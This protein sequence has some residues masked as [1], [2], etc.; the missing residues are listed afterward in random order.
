MRAHFLQNLALCHLVSRFNAVGAQ[1]RSVA[2]INFQVALLALRAAFNNR[3]SFLA[4]GISLSLSIRFSVRLCLTG[5]QVQMAGS[6]QPD[7]ALQKLQERRPAALWGKTAGD[8]PLRTCLGKRR[9][10]RR[11]YQI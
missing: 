9:F 8:F 3:E 1:L 6:L 2:K 4:I 7:G 11:F 5:N 10:E